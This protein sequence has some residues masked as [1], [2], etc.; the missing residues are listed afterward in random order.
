MSTYSLDIEDP[1]DAKALVN[2]LLE[3]ASDGNYSVDIQT[4]LKSY[5]SS[6]SAQVPIPVPEHIGAVVCTEG[7]PSGHKT[8]IRWTYDMHS[9][10]PW[11]AANDADETY[12]TDMIGRITKVR[13]AGVSDVV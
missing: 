2:V 11:I 8:F 10:S 9:T 13:S 6:I 4:L 3:A 7:S 1:A 12:R 5:A